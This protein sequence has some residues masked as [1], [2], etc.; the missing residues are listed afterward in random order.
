[1]NERF[2]TIMAANNN[3]PANEQE[4]LP[5]G[6]TEAQVRDAVDFTNR[7]IFDAA[8]SK[9]EPGALDPTGNRSLE[10]M[11]DGLEGQHEDD[12]ESEQA[13]EEAE[14]GEDAEGK[15][16]KKGEE[17]EDGEDDE[18][19]EEGED[20]GQGEDGEGEG[21]DGE[22]A[23]QEAAPPPAE[24]GRVPSGRLRE[25]TERATRAEEALRAMQAEREAER[26][27]WRKEMDDFR[28]FAQAALQGRAP[29]PAK[30]AAQPE[31]EPD[32]FENS[33]GWGDFLVKRATE[34]SREQAAA[35]ANQVRVDNSF[36]IAEAMH[37]EKF[38]KA[39]EACNKLDANNPE[40]RVTVQRILQARNPG[41]AVIDWHDRVER[42]R[43]LG[44]ESLADHDARVVK[45]AREAMIK[46]PEFRKQMLESIRSEASGQGGRP[47]RTAV[48]LP[49]SLNGASGSG[50][51]AQLT[52]P[53]A[54]D[55][56]DRAVFDSAW[57]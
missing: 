9:E 4:I 36:M 54:A 11:G 22:P 29:A 5:E 7:E 57:R 47:A 21:E 1:M 55:D 27:Q 35:L 20:E 13:D 56:S 16:A 50:A 43:T 44:S 34:S 40:D 51:N 14:D 25:Q 24:P 38:T 52:D 42:D 46:D 2:A 17:G 19:E 26:T 12:E 3:A 8:W 39:W 49:K 6:M 41:K 45:E 18:G 53:L 10:Q 48:R 23:G 37:G 28:A 30:D 32:V 15:E 33:K 31:S